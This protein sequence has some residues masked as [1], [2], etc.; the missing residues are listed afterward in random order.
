MAARFYL[1]SKPRL[2]NPYRT[3]Y[4]SNYPDILASAQRIGALLVFPYSVWN[5]DPPVDDYTA[6]L[7]LPPLK[8][9]VHINVTTATE[10]ATVVKQ[11]LKP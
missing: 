7:V 4:R 6:W 5:G 2:A 3:H 9:G 10:T 11:T 8:K 1:F